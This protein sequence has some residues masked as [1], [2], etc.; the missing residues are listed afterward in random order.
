MRFA[1]CRLAASDF[2][3]APA[4]SSERHSAI[5]N[6]CPT[7]CNSTSTVYQ[8]SVSTALPIA[9]PRWYFFSAS[10]IPASKRSST[11]R[12]CTQSAAH[13]VP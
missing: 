1:A 9:M 10:A 11:P 5:A 8:R 13:P 2:A 7:A 6:S 3:T 12:T 4:V